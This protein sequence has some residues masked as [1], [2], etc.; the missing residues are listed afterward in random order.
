[1]TSAN[2]NFCFVNT[3]VKIKNNLEL[4]NQKNFHF[5]PSCPEDS[6]KICFDQTGCEISINTN[7]KTVKKNSQTVWYETEALMFAA[8][9]SDKELYEC[10]VKR[11]LDR[12]KK[13]SKIYFEKSQNLNSINCNN[14]V[15]QALNGY[16][17][18]IDSYEVSSDLT[19]LYPLS[20]SMKNSN[21][22]SSCK[23]W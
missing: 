11:L 17:S 1:L 23:L 14:A 6:T 4:L 18:S 3:P 19:D 13:L 9:F 5:T 8:I 10:Q 20:Y 15:K 16:V 21:K 7:S 22:Y 2:E 12:T